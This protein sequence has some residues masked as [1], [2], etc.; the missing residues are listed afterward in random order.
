M[1][2]EDEFQFIQVLK[3]GT[4]ASYDNILTVIGN[5]PGEYEFAMTSQSGLRQVSRLQVTGKHC[6][7]VI[8]YS[9]FAAYLW[10][11]NWFLQLHKVQ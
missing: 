7:L 2:N 6:T 8:Y 11:L 5:Y 4:R 10:S 9:Y 1:N 3:D